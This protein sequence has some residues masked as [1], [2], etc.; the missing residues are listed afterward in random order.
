MNIKPPAWWCFAIE[1]AAATA[2]RALNGSTYPEQYK[3][4]ILDTDLH[5]FRDGESFDTCD[6]ESRGEA[7]KNHKRTILEPPFSLKYAKK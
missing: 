4:L 1:S 2:R 7:M 3:A 5:I 6:F